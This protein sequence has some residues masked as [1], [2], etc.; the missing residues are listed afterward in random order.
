DRLRGLLADA[1]ADALLVTSL[2]NIRYL[3]GFTGSAALLLV[4]PDRLVFV[5]D[6]R[7]RDQSADQ[8]AAASVGADI[9]IGRTSDD[10]RDL[11]TKAT[12]AVDRLGLEADHVTWAQQ[13]RYA[14]EWF[15]GAEVV[16]TTGLVEEL[17]LVKDAGEVPRIEAAWGIADAAMATVRPRLGEGATEAEIALD[18]EWHMRRLGAEGPSFDTIVASGPHGAKPPHRA[19]HR[20]LGEGVLRAM[21]FSPPV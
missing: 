11:L 14:G 16:A 9:E 7:Y 19:G 4:G 6:G 20:P 2:T 13:Q 18:L 17:R 1:G 3:T 5:T 8:L 15:P 12:G 10:Q 21:V